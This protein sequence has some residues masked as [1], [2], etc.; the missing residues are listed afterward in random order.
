MKPIDFYEQIEAFLNQTLSA[1]EMAAFQERLDQDPALRQELA[2]HRQI[3]QDYDAGR[4]QLRANLQA[5]MQEPLPPDT[6]ADKWRWARWLGLLSLALLLGFGVWRWQMPVDVAPAFNPETK[7]PAEPPAALPPVIDTMPKAPRAMAMGDPARFKPNPGMEAF[8]NSSLRSESVLVKMTRPRPGAQVM[9]NANETF[10]LRFTGSIQLPDDQQ[11]PAL[12]LAIFDNRDANKP[13]LSIPLKT[14]KSDAGK[15]SFD[16][17]QDLKYPMGLYYFTLE[18][19]GEV[20]Y[21]GKILLGK[22]GGQ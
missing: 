1:E 18:N 12:V 7:Q 14:Q 3:Q 5:I 16:R 4:L 9:P 17:R 15:W 2:L 22:N 6:T 10:N 19:D 8:V 11:N 20:L 21:A 13:L